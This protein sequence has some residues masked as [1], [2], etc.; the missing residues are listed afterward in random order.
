MWKYP[1]FLKFLYDLAEVPSIGEIIIIDNNPDATPNIINN[2]KFN[3]FTFGKNI[4]V[5]PAWNYGTKIAKYENICLLN[6]D[7]IVDLKLFH[8][9]DQFLR[10]GI[11]LCGICPG[12]KEEFGQTPVTNGEIDLV[13]CDTPYNYRTHFGLGTLMFYPKIEYIPIIDGLDLYWGDNFIYDTLY[14][15]LNRNYH[16]I[17]T[18]YYTPYAATTS[19]LTNTNDILNREHQLYNSVM[20]N[21]LKDIR[22]QNKHFTGFN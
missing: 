1:P 10:P 21:L 2:P 17:N 15:K 14:Y 22:D 9:M 6:D 11:G 4:Y 5:N 19:T 16:I 8:R 12:L 13:H 3:I 7:V 18:F 20:P